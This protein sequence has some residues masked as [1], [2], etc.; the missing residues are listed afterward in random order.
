MY[1]PGN[2]AGTCDEKIEIEAEGR[3]D[4]TACENSHKRCWMDKE[5]GWVKDKMTDTVKQQ[6]ID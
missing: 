4:K 3:K 5:S 6:G 1:M 2:L